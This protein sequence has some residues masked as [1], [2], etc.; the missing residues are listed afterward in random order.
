MKVFLLLRVFRPS[1]DEGIS[2][3]RPQHPQTSEWHRKRRI[4]MCYY[5]HDYTLLMA[6]FMAQ[7]VG[8]FGVGHCRLPTVGTHNIACHPGVVEGARKAR[9]GDDTARAT[10]YLLYLM[11]C[12]RRLD[13]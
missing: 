3:T 11:C 13:V 1:G 10:V 9:P 4:F 5:R 8:P 6:L 2:T 12:Y 7:S